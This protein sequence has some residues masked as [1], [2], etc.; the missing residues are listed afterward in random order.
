MSIQPEQLAMITIFDWVR[1]HKLDKIIWHTANERKCSIQYGALLK[2]MGVIP[3]VTD[4]T[5]ARAKNGYNGAYLEVKVGKNKPTIN[6]IQFMN[7][8]NE[9]G[10]FT[11]TVYGADETINTIKDYLEGNVEVI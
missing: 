11:K 1:L 10:Y 2:R 6:Q 7:A 3:G 9:E 8:M 5:I 4:I